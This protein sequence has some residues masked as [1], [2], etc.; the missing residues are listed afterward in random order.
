MNRLCSY[1]NRFSTPTEL[2]AE[3]ADKFPD[4][5]A[6]LEAQNPLDSTARREHKQQEIIRRMFYDCNSWHSDR[7]VEFYATNN[8]CDINSRNSDGDTLLHLAVE[9]PALFQSYIHSLLYYGANPELTDAA[10]RNVWER[11]T[12]K[13]LQWLKSRPSLLPGVDLIAI[14]LHWKASDSECL[15]GIELLQND[16]KLRAAVD[17]P[18]KKRLEKLGSPE[19]LAML[20]LIAKAQRHIHNT[21]DECQDCLRYTLKVGEHLSGSLYSPAVSNEVEWATVCES[22]GHR[23]SIFS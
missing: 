14:L 21:K 16:P 4:L 19:A 3:Q 2:A 6:F 23:Q 1:E 11:A 17:K 7:Y 15:Q 18:E 9:Y 12:P 22:C 5:A 8:I 13:I 20:K 10:G